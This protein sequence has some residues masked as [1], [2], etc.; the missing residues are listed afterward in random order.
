MSENPGLLTAS[1]PVNTL[2]DGSTQ[3]FAPA[4]P[5]PPIPIRMPTGLSSASHPL[6]SPL[7]GCHVLPFVLLS[8]LPGSAHRNPGLVL[9]S[10][11][12]SSRWDTRKARPS[13]ALQTEV[14]SVAVGHQHGMLLLSGQSRDAMTYS[15]AGEQMLS[16]LRLVLVAKAK[17]VTAKS[18]RRDKGPA[19]TAPPSCLH[20]CCFSPVES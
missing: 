13:T 17:S 9:P 8:A 15:A 2:S 1:V 6:C 3:R 19:G 7:W 18:N 4:A 5:P 11:W 16:S 14:L 20:L 10:P 12:T